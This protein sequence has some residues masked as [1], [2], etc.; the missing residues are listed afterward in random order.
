MITLPLNGDH[1]VKQ[2]LGAFRLSATEVAFA[3]FRPHYFPGA[4]HL[5]PFGGRFMGFQ[6]ILFARFLLSCH[7][8]YLSYKF[9]ALNN[10]RGVFH[11]LEIQRNQLI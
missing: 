6:L 4:G 5:E 8:A 2:L 1:L 3:A 9:R 10:G 7:D 11:S